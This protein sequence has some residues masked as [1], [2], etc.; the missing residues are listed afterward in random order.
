MFLN[1]LLSTYA[2]EKFEPIA[3]WL[4]IGLLAALLLVGV[5]LFFGKREAFNAYLKYALIGTAA[6]LLV[7]AILFFSLDIAKNYSD[8][9]AEENWLEKRLLIKY[10]LVPLLV[11][12]S[13]SLLTLLGYALADHFKPEAKKTVLIVGLA[14]FTAALIA[15]VV[16]ITTYYN[17][18]IAND[19]YYNSDTASVKPLGLYLALAACICAYAVFFLIDKQAFSFDSRSL[20][21]AGIC[22][23][24]SFALSYVKLWDMPAG[25]SVTLVSLLP[26]MLYSYI[27]GTKKGIFVGFT[28]GILQALQDPWLIHPAQFF[29]DYPVAFAAVGIAGLFRSVQ[30]LEKLPQVKFTLGAVLAGIMRFV[31]HV[32][33]GALAFEAYAPA[34][35]NVWLYSL[36]YNAYVFIDA[37]LVI[38]A[39]ILVLSSKAFVQYTEKLGKEKKTASTTAKTEPIAEN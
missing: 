12:A 3:K 10:V 13:V 34:G 27:F 33:S 8:S 15:V 30:G 7:L 2:V 24:M 38:A 26:L 21:Y 16:C 5:L 20:A 11:L 31:C 19:G 1:S 29:I 18:K 9:Y 4:T 17:Q 39:G 35:Q 28:Y 32:L 14:L 22:V 36:G 37:A 23:A 6:Y 25:G